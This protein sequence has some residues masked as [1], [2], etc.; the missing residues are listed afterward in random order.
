[1]C[2]ALFIIIIQVTEAEL[3][4][5]KAGLEIPNCVLEAHPLVKPIPRLLHEITLNGVKPPY[6]ELTLR[7]PLTTSR[8]GK[9]IVKYI[10]VY[11]I[12]A[13]NCRGRK[14]L[15]ITRK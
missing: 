15:W 12:V 3:D 7:L 4:D 5:F 11:H 8:K 6:N 2:T 10:I 9:F 13:G 14:C 1:M